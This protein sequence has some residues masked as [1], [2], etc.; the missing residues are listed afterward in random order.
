MI[1]VTEKTILLDIND[2][3]QDYLIELNNIEKKIAYIKKNKEKLDNNYFVEDIDKIYSKLIE[4]FNNVE[5]QNLKD[6]LLEY[7]NIVKDKLN[8]ICEHEWIDDYID[9]DPEKSQ[10]ICYCGICGATKQ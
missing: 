2:M 5:I 6:F 1:M 10:P 4:I 7:Q 3:V 8:N 9:I